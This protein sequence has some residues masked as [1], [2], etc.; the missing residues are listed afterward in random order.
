MK[1]MRRGA[2]DLKNGSNPAV[3]ATAVT[4]LGLLLAFAVF[5]QLALSRL[6]LAEQTW[7]THDRKATEISTQLETLHRHIG[8]GGF[9]H[10]FKNYVLRRD[11][12]YRQ[13]IEVDLQ[14]IS[15]VLDRL[16]EVLVV[17]E[18]DR[19][20]AVIRA[21]FDEYRRN[22]LASQSMVDRGD[23]PTAIDAVVK[24][25][26]GP[27]LMAIDHLRSRITE[28]SRQAEQTAEERLADALRF[29]SVGGVLMILATL[30]GASVLV[31]FLRRLAAA[32]ED[33][34]STRHQ[35]DVLLNTSPD[36][37]INADRQGIMV[38]VNDATS[39]MFGYSREELL[40]QPVEMLLPQALRQVHAGYRDEYFL[41]PVHRPMGLGGPLQAVTRD[42]RELDVEISLSHSGEGADQTATVA[43]R[44]ISDR[45]RD[46]RALE[47]ALTQLQQAQ[48]VLV[49]SEKMA[50]LGGLVAG[51]A[52]EIN[53]PIGVV[54]T[55]ATFLEA[56]AAKVR[57]RYEAGELDGDQLEDHF[58]LTLDSMRMIALNIHRAADLV[59]GFKQVAV[60]QTSGERRTFELKAYID[61]VMLSLTP[62]LKGTGHK[63]S[64]DCPDGIEMDSYPGALAQ[65][66]GNL[67][68]NSLVHAFPDGR[69]GELSVAVRLVGDRVELVY[70]D[71]GCGIPAEL[72]AKV[73]DPFFTTKRGAGGSGLGLHIL[74]NIVHQ[75]LK[76]SLD[77]ESSVET[78]TRF[79]LRIPLKLAPSGQA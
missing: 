46:R 68:I 76:G 2:V 40:G 15:E 12:K 21:T 39:T 52:H 19:A 69:A 41:H 67:V 7:I 32:H 13:R 6:H 61:E 42:G 3:T 4:G 56:E 57:A 36:P 29:L 1:R 74:Y 62:K 77:F 26:D 47:Q 30:A 27:A 23:T 54:L 60:D 22:Y 78:G 49:Q 72:Q 51:V 71:N 58:R 16:D 75:T 8:Y 5:G 79:T 55:S 10:N 65:C 50:A 31:W 11:A 9:I 44:D 25:D 48:K 33:L 70:A 17:A 34:E 14:A 53:T 28:R 37:M 35:L 73:F 24:V 64:V 38:R 20:L 43:I 63:I 66:M 45:E 59:H 18:D